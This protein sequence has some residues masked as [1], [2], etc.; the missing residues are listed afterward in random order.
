M[1]R[2]TGVK[3][4]YFVGF[5]TKQH[6]STIWD[7]TPPTCITILV[8]I[9]AEGLR[10]HK[11]S[12]RIQ[13][14]QLTFYRVFM[15]WVSLAPGGQGRWV[16][17]YLGTQKG[18]HTCTHTCVYICI[19]AHACNTKTYMLRNCKWLLPWRQLCL[20]WLTCMGMCVQ[21][22]VC[23]CMHMLWYLWSPIHFPLHPTHGC[24]VSHV[25]FI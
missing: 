16:G 8:Y 10:G 25:S 22:Y 12:N 13:I 23:M 17:E 11:S 3:N 18:S 2:V 7:W 15:I 5:K 6:K 1:C 21:M 9:C 24:H 20:S 14:L 4:M 19:Y